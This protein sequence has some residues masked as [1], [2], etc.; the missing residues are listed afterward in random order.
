MMDAGSTTI[1]VAERMI[2]PDEVLASVRPGHGATL[3][4]GLPGTALL[5]ARLSGLDKVFEQAAAA[6]WARAADLAT[7]STAYGGLYHVL[8]G[9]A[10][11]L[12]I[13][14]PYLPDPEVNRAAI[15]RA[16]R[17]ASAFATALAEQQAGLVQ[18]GGRGTPWNVYDVI[19]GLAGVGR[20]LL[21]AAGDGHA[22]AEPGLVSALGSLTVTLSDRHGRPGWWAAPDQH[23]R[24]VAATL[25]PSGAATTGV[26]HGV[27]GPL[28]LLAC[29]GQAGFTVTGQDAA[30]RHAAAWL[31]RWKTASHRWPVH[32]A[33]DELDTGQTTARPGR[34]TAWCYGAP[35]IGRALMLAGQALGDSELIDAG[36]TALCGLVERPTE[37]DAEGPTLCHGYAGVMRCAAGVDDTVAELAATAIARDIDPGRPFVFAHSGHDR[38][39]DYP[40]FLT[41]A[42][43]VG[44]VLA[45]HADLPAAQ[46]KT[47]WDALL[48]LS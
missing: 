43:G 47:S 45:D 1:T 42:A 4:D 40:G 22:D 35:G 38:R 19:S 48:L 11:S 29:A 26:A 27:A 14:S 5:H 46:V 6:H 24:L 31:L 18:A 28:A 41:G 10:G 30:V 8:G 3:A 20:V 2:D 37:W 17:W 21:A 15:R 13:G 23:P 39:H 44:L 34:N 25:G 9:M 33:G 7:R 12:V 36:R 16:V 32:L